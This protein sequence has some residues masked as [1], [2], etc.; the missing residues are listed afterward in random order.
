MNTLTTTVCMALGVIA[1]CLLAAAIA[2]IIVGIWFEEKRKFVNEQWTKLANILNFAAEQ[3]TKK[4][5][6]DTHD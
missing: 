1:V 5:K 3:L 2:Q 4:S 6:E